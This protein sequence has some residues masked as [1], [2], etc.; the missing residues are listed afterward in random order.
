M[1]MQAVIDLGGKKSGLEGE[2]I[3]TKRSIGQGS[4]VFGSL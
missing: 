2:E 1:A 3:N 4:E